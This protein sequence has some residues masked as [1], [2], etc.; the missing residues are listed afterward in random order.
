L[1][2]ASEN[3]ILE[4]VEGTVAIPSDKQTSITSKSIVTPN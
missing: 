3:G 2:F 1:Q 4:V